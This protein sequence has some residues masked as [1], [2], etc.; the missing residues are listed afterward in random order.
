MIGAPGGPSHP[1]PRPDV[2]PNLQGQNVG[3]VPQGI[4][5]VGP[6]VDHRN[7]GPFPYQASRGGHGA[8]IPVKMVPRGQDRGE[9]RGVF[10]PRP[11]VGYPQQLHPPTP[12]VAIVPGYQVRDQ[13]ALA[14]QGHGNL[15]GPKS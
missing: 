14:S 10:S 15:M 11:D 12:E 6:V 7:L 3:I 1:G 9:K 5:P 4:Q 13:N 2:K 8:V